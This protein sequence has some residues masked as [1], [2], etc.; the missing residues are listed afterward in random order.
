MA[1][2]RRRTP[3]GWRRL[4]RVLLVLLLLL[5][6]PLL[7]WWLVNRFDEAPS[8]A[9]LR[10]SAPD[11]RAV[12]DAD[13][14]W[15]HLAGI[16]A[17]A[18]EAPFTYGRRRVDVLGA[19]LRQSPA[20]PADAVEQALF[21]D[22]LPAVAPESALDGVAEL[23]P[24]RKTDCIAWAREHRPALD[25]LQ[26]ANALR[27]QRYRALLLLRD[28]QGLYPA[29][30]DSPFPDTTVAALHRNL[31]ARDLALALDARDRPALGDALGQLADSVEFWRRV[32]PQATDVFSVMLA[33]SQLEAAQ[34]LVGDL[35][36]AD[37][38]PDASLEAPIDRILQPLPPDIAW[39]QALAFEYQSFV[40]S[41]RA[42]LPG[43]WGAL[44]QC[45]SGTSADGCL[46]QL[47]MDAAFVPQAS[48][49]LH[50]ANIEAMQ[51]W[52][53][54]DARDVDAAGEAYSAH[55]ASVSVRLDDAGIVLRQ[56]V[57][58]YVGRILVNIAIP[59]S[60]WGLRLHDR[61][62]LRRMLVIK[63]DALRQQVPGSDMPA[64]LQ[65]QPTDLRDPYSG[66][67]FGWEPQTGE[68][69]FAPKARGYWE[70]PTLSVRYRGAPR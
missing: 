50:A 53:E 64:F 33:S 8:A 24:S 69:Q 52:L 17:P 40:D 66:E 56:M 20:P 39:R 3:S 28:W 23:C 25:R 31:I 15:L 21:A 18:D 10:Y 12:A 36:D 37:T 34:R 27:L 30:F 68:L 51:R 16:G 26:Q 29:A 42:A 1:R 65:A 41:M 57:Y 45:V 13:N 38:A 46:A 2:S 35:L 9:A 59:K 60:D 48:F 11:P 14:A 49:N 4:A 22:A 47:G 61:E 44:R 58:N 6:S 32:P 5:L 19:R 67:A 54:A 43:A 7:L 55:V 70:Q 63:R 62:A